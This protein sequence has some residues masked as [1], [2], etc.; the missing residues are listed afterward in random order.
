MQILTPYTGSESSSRATQCK[1]F[2]RIDTNTDSEIWDMPTTYIRFFLLFNMGN[3]TMH[4]QPALLKTFDLYLCIFFQ[5][6][7]IFYFIPIVAMSP[8][9]IIQD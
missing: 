3:P 2:A 8:Y 5:P 4:R 1:A 9:N 7:H 6:S